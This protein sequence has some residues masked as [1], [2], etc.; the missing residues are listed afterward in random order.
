MCTSFLQQIKM[1]MGTVQPPLTAQP[2]SESD[3][4][5]SLLAEEGEKD[6]KTISW[7]VLC[8]FLFCFV[9]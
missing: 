8:L 9:L 4:E 5:P 1:T 3:E 2:T 6:S 7:I